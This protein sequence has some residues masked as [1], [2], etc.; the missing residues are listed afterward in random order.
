MFPTMVG[1]GWQRVHVHHCVFDAAVQGKQ[2]ASAFTRDLMGPHHRGTGVHR[3]VHVYVNTSS[4][5]V[6]CGWWWTASA[7]AATSVFLNPQTTEFHD[8]NHLQQRGANFCFQFTQSKRVPILVP[9]WIIGVGT[10]IVVLFS[11]FHRCFV[12]SSVATCHR[13]PAATHS[14]RSRRR[15]TSRT[16]R[17]ST[18]SWTGTQ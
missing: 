6:L 17:T 8:T 10:I 13:S 4:C 14:H 16:S 15:G 11:S 5:S 7:S 12:S 2:H 1:R 18:F 9:A 3:Y